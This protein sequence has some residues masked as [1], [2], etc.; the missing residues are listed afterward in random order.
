MRDILKYPKDKEDIKFA[1]ENKFEVLDLV[2]NIDILEC[3]I[4]KL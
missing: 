3:K 2:K 4:V 1:L